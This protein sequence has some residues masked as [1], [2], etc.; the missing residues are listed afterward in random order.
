MNSVNPDNELCKTTQWNTLVRLVF[1]DQQYNS[2][3]Q[4]IESCKPKQ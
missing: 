1:K 4:H 2:V 3:N